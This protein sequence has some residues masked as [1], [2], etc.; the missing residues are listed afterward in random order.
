MAAP[1]PR[2]ISRVKSHRGGR[3]IVLYQVRVTWE[4]RREL[5]GRFD[6][7]TDARMA[8][9]LARADVI[10][11]EF[12]PPRILRRDAVARVRARQE[13]RQRARLTVGQ[14]SEQWL[15]HVER[16]GGK[17]S[18]IYSYQRRLD[19][20]VLPTFATT[21]AADVT[22][23]DV[24][25]W[26]NG[27]DA[28]HGNG[29]SRGA[30][31]AL[32]SMFNYATGKAKGQNASFMPLLER[33]PCGI[34]GAAQH[35]AVNPSEAIEKVITP[36]QIAAIARNMPEVEQLSVLL[37]GY[38]ALRIG[39]VLGLQRHDLDGDRL[40]IRRQA[41]SR[42]AGLVY[43]T[44]KSK[45]GIRALP[46]PGVL[47]PAIVAHLE[48]NMA[49]ADDAPMFPRAPR[50][51]KP[52]APNT[53]RRHFDAALAAA[54]RDGAKIPSEFV[55]HGLRHTALTN[56]GRIGATMAELKLWAGHADDATVQR[57]QWAT[58]DRM[59]AQAARLDVQLPNV[60]EM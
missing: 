21:P 24:E 30:Y 40:H 36:A 53:L 16:M 42:G 9:D 41:Q 46:I 33:S 50:G 19:K 44:P 15:A 7:L 49:A 26:F 58:R 18:T 14:L 32:S 8:A 11:R 6:T 27:L 25:D 38:M 48:S 13:D 10:R 20:H 57:Y 28:A 22:P 54:N 59:T 2:G 23:E 4:G 12:V 34:S 35:K 37:A 55:F 60:E 3:E 51:E 5:V 39:E 1:L 43:S 17:A 29:V 52:A 31:M 47:L 45:A 56:L